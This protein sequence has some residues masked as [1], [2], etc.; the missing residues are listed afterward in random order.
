MALRIEP[1]AR[2]RTVAVKDTG[3]R[4]IETSNE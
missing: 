2:S 4:F 3:L 1:L